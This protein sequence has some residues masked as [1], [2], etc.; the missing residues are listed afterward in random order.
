MWFKYGLTN[1]KFICIYYLENSYINEFMTH[2]SLYPVSGHL[3]V[4]LFIW[5]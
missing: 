5:I 1:M 4:C 2:V 3:G